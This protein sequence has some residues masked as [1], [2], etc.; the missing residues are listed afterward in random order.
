[1]IK[2]IIKHLLENKIKDM[3][4]DEFYDTFKINFSNFQNDSLLKKVV[5]N[6]HN[7]KTIYTSNDYILV[8]VRNSIRGSNL[9]I[10]PDNS[11]LSKFNS[12]LSN[13]INNDL[14]LYKISESKLIDLIDRQTVETVCLIS[15][16]KKK[17]IYKVE[18]DLSNFNIKVI[19]NSNIKREIYFK[20]KIESVKNN[21][22]TLSYIENIASKYDVLIDT[23]KLISKA[24]FDIKYP[25]DVENYANSLDPSI[26][27]SDRIDYSNILTYTIDGSDTKDMDDAIS[28]EKIDNLYKIGVHIADVSYY[29]KEDSIIDKEA[30]KR[31]TST[32]LG[33]IV[34]PMLPFNLSNNLCSLVENNKRLALSV[35]H[36]FDSNLNYIDYSI[37]KTIINS[38]YK[39]TYDE[40]N[41]YLNNN[42][43]P[44]NDKNLDFSLDILQKISQNINEYKENVGFIDF[45]TKELKFIFNDKNEVSDVYIRHSD[46]AEKLIENFMVLTN[47]TVAKHLTNLNY[48][49]VYRIHE[50]PDITEFKQLLLELNKYNISIGQSTPL[51]A[52]NISKILNLASQSSL[53]TIIS[54]KIL[55][56]MPKAYYDNILQGHFGLNSSIYTHFTSPIRRYPDLILHRIISDLIFSK[57]INVLEKIKYY[58]NI[59]PQIL[60]ENNVSEKKSVSLERQVEKLLSIKYLLKNDHRLFNGQIVHNTESGFFVKLENG[61]EGFVRLG[62]FYDYYQYNK[63]SDSYVSDKGKIYKLGDKIRVKIEKLDMERLLIDLEVYD[64]HNSK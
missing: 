12:K 33:N 1:M 60:K 28:F 24:S 48:P 46:K 55:K 5:V 20:A 13:Y 40:V 42:I 56:I 3:T 50:K 6:N 37:E 43:S 16:K 57:N 14:V 58:D 15:Y 10:Y 21:T 53:S 52:K 32:Y 64:K 35:I 2:K 19:P 49:S 41:N 39:L 51:N 26:D 63:D 25:K 11:L 22:L 4:Y 62:T 38:N 61:I 29:V 45:D 59:L 23:Y 27:S 8:K 9:I 30:L 47:E 34:L 36:T 7:K 31:G 54:S 44:R 18:K 17:L